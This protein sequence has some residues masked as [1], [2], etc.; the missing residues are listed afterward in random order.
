MLYRIA[1]ASTATTL[2]LATTALAEQHMTAVTDDAYMSGNV[3]TEEMGNLIRVS[4]LTDGDVYTLNAEVGESDWDTVGYYNEVDA[5]W[6]QIGNVTDVAL[7]PDGSMAGLVVETGGFLDIGD[8]HVLLSA[9]DY[10]M[11]R[12]AGMDSYSFVTRLS[13][14]ELQNL[15]EV[16]ENWW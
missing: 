2:A 9:D 11:V 5:E 15:P 16:G 8:S 7:A 3:A 6:D 14:E 1:A 12:S 13:E 10:R 4:E